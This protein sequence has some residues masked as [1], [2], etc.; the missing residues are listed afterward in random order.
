MMPADIPQ[1]VCTLCRGELE[2]AACGGGERHCRSCGRRYPAVLG[3]PDLRPPSKVPADPDKPIVDRLLDAYDTSGYAELM[4]IYFAA[5]GHI[6]MPA[7]DTADHYRAYT[8]RQFARGRQ[9]TEMFFS[10]RRTQ[11]TPVADTNLIEIGCG[12]GAGLV[13]KALACRHVT[14]LDPSLPHLILAHKAAEEYNLDN[15][16]LVQALGQQMPYPDCAFEQVIAQ[17][18]LDHVFD[19]EGIIREVARVLRPGGFFAADSRN[20]FDLFFPEPHVNLRWVGFLPRSWARKY[21]SWRT[22]DDY[23]HTQLLSYWDLKS[24]MRHHF[25]D[26]YSIGFPDIGV[27]GVRSA[28][29]VR[30]LD[31]LE[32]LGAAALPLLWFFPAH[33]VVAHKP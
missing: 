30:M 2:L 19:L 23:R 25:A 29:A 13:A 14:G 22:P 6:C 33:L 21:V 26:N 32:R 17:H 8:D 7:A 18:V 28:S 20:R 15:I 5:T 31:V 3:I 11:G 10:R 9:F 1:P 16:S 24:A 12:A 27:Y 4:D